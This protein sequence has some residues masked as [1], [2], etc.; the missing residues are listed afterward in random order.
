MPGNQ[1]FARLSHTVRSIAVVVGV[2][3]GVGIPLS[4][5]LVAYY[6]QVSSLQYRTGLAAERLAEYV[7]V[8]GKSWRFSENRIADMIGFIR[9]DGH[10]IVYDAAGRHVA[11]IGPPVAWP[12]LR[13]ASAIVV[14]GEA[15]GRVEAEVSLIPLLAQIGILSLLGIVLG[16]AVFVGAL[17]IPQRALRGAAAAHDAVQRDL[18]AQIGETQSALMMAKEATSAKSAFLAMMSHEIRTPMNAVMGLSSS[19]LDSRL[20]GEQRH[21]VE[22]IYESSNGLLRL[23]NDLLDFSKLDAG[24]IELE[25][26]AF[27]PAALVDHAVSIVAAKAAEK[28]LA[29]RTVVEPGLPAALRGDPARLQ[30][31]VLNLAVNAIKFTEAGAVEIGAR[32]LHQGAATATLECWVRDTGIGVAPEQV[33]TLFSEFTQADVSISRRFGGTGLGLAISKRIV[34]QMRGKIEVAS[35]PG[36]G[37]TFAFQVTLPKTEAAALAEALP[38]SGGDDLAAVFKRLA[39]PLRVLLAEDNGTNQLVFSKLVQDFRI[40]LTIAADGREALERARA[41]TFD[42]VFMDM[43]MPEMD[44]LEATRA[45]RALG[46]A[47]NHTPIVALTANAFPEDVKDCREAGMNDFI[48]KPIRKKVLLERTAAVLADH[49]LLRAVASLRAPAHVAA[50]EPTSVLERATVDELIEALGNAEVRRLFDV[51]VAETVAR[52]ELMS[53][54]CCP[55]DRARIHDEA[56]SLKGAAGT[57]GLSELSELAG[58]LER[59][60]ATIAPAD[61]PGALQRLEQGF[62]A[63]RVEIGR[64]LAGMAAAA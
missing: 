24:K 35:T 54:L 13:V 25:E 51:F 27:S 42:I 64:L 21:L 30:Q 37:S 29:I 38:P 34:E 60:A 47:W 16:G 10:Q 45:I 23:L 40:D 3:A 6:S 18:R 48:S 28:G 49:P 41:G 5:G 55:H 1:S 57:A 17:L 14:R 19:L 58:A 22:T 26:I 44:G 31:V 11:D 63:A 15:A 46:G 2:T 62:S 8:A 39:R 59:A 4:F 61:Y 9:I 52:L 53:G 43:R 33:G 12:A 56:H 50:V 32:C 7:Y 20:D 36:A